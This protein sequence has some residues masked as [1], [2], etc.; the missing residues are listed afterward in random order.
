M[1][2]K[3]D[4]L[5]GGKVLCVPAMPPVSDGDPRWVVAVVSNAPADLWRPRWVGFGP[6]CESA[7]E[8]SGSMSLA[9]LGFRLAAVV[10]L[11]PTH[12]ASDPGKSF[13]DAAVVRVEVCP[14][15]RCAAT[16]ADVWVGGADRLAEDIERIVTEARV[17]SPAEFLKSHA[18]GTEI[19]R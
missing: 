2:D 16:G 1:Y 14:L 13:H 19:D 7:G 15:I 4:S 3:Y 12:R 8:A 10:C 18:N 5:Y 6:L 17:V 9:R 11:T